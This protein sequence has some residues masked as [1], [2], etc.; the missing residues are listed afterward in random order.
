MRLICFPTFG[1]VLLISCVVAG[2][3]AAPITMQALRVINQ[4]GVES[5]QARSGP[6]LCFTSADYNLSMNPNSCYRLTTST[7]LQ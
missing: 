5:F 7:S 1:I 3:W 4:E 6:A 2:Q